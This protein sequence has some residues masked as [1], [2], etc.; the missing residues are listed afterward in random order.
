M[1]SVL[2]PA[3]AHR[4]AFVTGGASGIGRATAL[5]FA[6]RGA[7]VVVADRDERGAERTADLIREAG[8]DAEP[9][10]VDVGAREEVKLAVD[11]TV[12]SFGRLDY[13]FNNAG[14]GAPRRP[15]AEM[16]EDE[17]DEVWRV[18]VKGVWNC[19][20]AEIPVMAHRGGGAIV[21]TASATALRATP[22][23]SCYAVTKA[24]VIHLTSVAAAECAAQGIR[25]NA[26]CPGPIRTPMLDHLPPE[27]IA[28]L[29]H[30]VPLGR[31]GRADEV[32]AAV[33]WLCSD[34]AGYA[35][36]VAL[37]LDGGEQL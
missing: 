25:V 10:A 7:K 5:A 27:R 14:V 20:C 19:L 29:E 21:N 22:G 3:G 31:L 13:A 16:K 12:R 24:A 35:T 11:E 1:G 30:G 9:V 32:A 2:D 8:G 28:A 17:L 4:V 34:A 26:V 6:G 36:G 18:N 33:V 37:A 23:M 15:V